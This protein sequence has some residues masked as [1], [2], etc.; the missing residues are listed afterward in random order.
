MFALFTFLK[1]FAIK[2]MW[3]YPRTTQCASVDSTFMVNGVVNTTLYEQ[4]ANF[5]KEPTFNK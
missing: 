3:R 1:S 4:Y 5:D 2:N